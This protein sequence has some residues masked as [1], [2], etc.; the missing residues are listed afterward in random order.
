MPI[1]YTDFLR[2]PLI[3]VCAVADVSVVEV[4]SSQAAF[5]ASVLGGCFLSV[6]A[7]RVRGGGTCTPL[8]ILDI[9]NLY[10]V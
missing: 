3:R 6:S 2:P 1:F 4:R 9:L 7:P 10:R 5:S 8:N